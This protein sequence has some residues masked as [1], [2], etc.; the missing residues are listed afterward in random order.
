MDRILNTRPS[1]VLADYA[2]I[3]EDPAY[4]IIEI[5]LNSDNL[6]F[7]FNNRTLPLHHYHYDRFVSPDDEIHGKWSLTFSTDAQG[8]IQKVN[9]SLDQK[10]VIFTKKADPRLKDP[11]FLKNLV[12]QYELNGTSINLVLSNNELMIR[13]APPQHLE[14]YKNNIFKI[15]EFPDRLVEFIFDTTGSPTGFKLTYD[16]KT[17]LYTKK[18]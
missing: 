8:S 17:D 2:G 11:N 13:S 16:G 6:S 10:E 3:Y 12:G 4:G 9:I 15:R 7:T 18:K 1:H 5:A 14:P